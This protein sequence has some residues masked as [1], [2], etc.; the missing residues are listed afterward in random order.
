MDCKCMQTKTLSDD[1]SYHPTMMSMTCRSAYNRDSA[2][3]NTLD[4]YYRRPC[5][6]S[7]DAAAQGT[8]LA[9]AAVRAIG[10]G[11]TLLPSMPREHAFNGWGHP[12]SPSLGWVSYASVELESTV[13]SELLAQKSLSTRPGRD[14]AASIVYYHYNPGLLWGLPPVRFFVSLRGRSTVY[15]SII[16]QYF[17]MI[18]ACT[19]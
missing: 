14:L 16:E 2:K 19:S 1:A 5:L 7:S 15:S 4:P 11:C 10:L 13:C 3:P 12:S 8:C 18:L 9:L 17:D 6:N